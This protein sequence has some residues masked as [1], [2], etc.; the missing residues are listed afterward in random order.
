MGNTEELHKVHADE[1]LFVGN[2]VE[3]HRAGPLPRHYLWVI[4]KRS[5]KTMQMRHYL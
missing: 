2:I 4:Q 5:I 1:T 3:I